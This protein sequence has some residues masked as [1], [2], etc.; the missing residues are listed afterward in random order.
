MEK[1]KVT[2][3]VVMEDIIRNAEKNGW[4][5]NP[6]KKAVERVRNGIVKNIEKYGERYCPCVIISVVKEEKRKDYICPCVN[7]KAEIEEDNQCHCSLYFKKEE[8]P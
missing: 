6:D 5:L 3:E 8:K 4:D 2:K 1:Y 7:A